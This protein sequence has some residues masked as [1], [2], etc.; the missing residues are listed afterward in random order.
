M[1]LR[2]GLKESKPRDALK[3]D[4][5]HP[6][7]K[8]PRESTLPPAECRPA[9][10]RTGRGGAGGKVPALSPQCHDFQPRLY[11]SC[12][13]C[14]SIFKNYFVLNQQMGAF[15]VALWLVGFV[16]KIRFKRSSSRRGLAGGHAWQR[17]R[18]GP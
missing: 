17:G 9:T 5:N 11:R 18:G 13:V 2:S 7:E 4:A 10:L 14:Y 12:A 3:E 16:L 1:P 8:A 6:S 15:A